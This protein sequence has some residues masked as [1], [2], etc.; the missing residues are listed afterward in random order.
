MSKENRKE[1]G[2]GYKAILIYRVE[3]VAM[4]D[5]ENRAASWQILSV[6]CLAS[7]L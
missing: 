1:S 4:K 3:W 6:P 7:P 2:K 5:A